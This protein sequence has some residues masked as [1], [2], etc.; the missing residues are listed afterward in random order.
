VPEKRGFGAKLSIHPA[1]L[2]P[3]RHAF[4]PTSEELAWHAVSSLP[5]ALP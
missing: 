3:V 4:G 2:L 5:L 1:Q